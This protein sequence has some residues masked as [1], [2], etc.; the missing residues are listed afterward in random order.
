MKNIID[1]EHLLKDNKGN[2]ELLRKV[3]TFGFSDRVIAHRWEMTEAEIT[4]LRHKHNIRP[5]Y[6]MVDTC[7]A[8]FASNTPY[9]YSTY[10]FENESTRGDKEKIVVLGSGPIRIGQGIEFDYATVHAIKA[11]KKNGL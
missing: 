9:F 5:V 4:E 6:K 2:I 1:L 7:A 11:N 10:E 8:E 3:K